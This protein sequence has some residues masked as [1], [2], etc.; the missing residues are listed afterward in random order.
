VKPDRSTL[1]RAFAPHTILL[2]RVTPS[3]FLID[4]EPHDRLE[5]RVTRQQLLRKRFQDGKL[6]CDS[7]DGV[8]ARNGTRCETCLHDQCRP[9]L[10]IHLASTE[11][12]YVLDLAVTSAQ[13]LLALEDQVSADAPALRDSTLRLTV[14]D[15]GRW[16]EVC[17]EIVA[18]PPRQ[19]TH[20][21]LLD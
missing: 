6:V 19:A 13:N 7:T 5:G 10:R 2:V 17:F 15:R 14:R 4:G 20:K 12:T 3:G 11:R 18:P 8:R 21:N 16:G 9:W 1:L